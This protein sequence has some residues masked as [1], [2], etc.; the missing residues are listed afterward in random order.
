MN[1]FYSDITGKNYRS[2]AIRRQAENK[3]LWYN[4]FG[5]MAGYTKE[6]GEKLRKEYETPGD[7]SFLPEEPP[8]AP[9]FIIPYE[10]FKEEWHR[11]EEE[12]APLDTSDPLLAFLISVDWEPKLSEIVEASKTHPIIMDFFYPIIQSEYGLVFW[13]GED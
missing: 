5:A 11:Y 10:V 2:E 9:D 13:N 7:D 1:T 6:H 8:P 4:R 3:S 12:N